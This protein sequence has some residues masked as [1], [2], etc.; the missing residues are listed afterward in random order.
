MNLRKFTGRRQSARD[1]RI[2]LTLGW[3]FHVSMRRVNWRRAIYFAIIF[4]VIRDPVRKLD[5]EESVLI[6]VSVLVL[7]VMISIGAWISS[8]AENSPCF[9][10]P[11]E[12]IDLFQAASCSDR[13]CLSVSFAIYA[14]GYKMVASALCRT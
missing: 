9:K 11:S 12:V 14:Q 10:I 13:A 3:G 8:Q 5:P 2:I 1:Y 4:D 6:T 7:W